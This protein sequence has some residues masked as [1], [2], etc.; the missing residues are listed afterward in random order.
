M[1]G[2][3]VTV[4]QKETG[5]S[6]TEYSENILNFAMQRSVELKDLTPIV[7]TTAA[8]CKAITKPVEFEVNDLLVQISTPS[9]I[10][11]P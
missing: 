10:I 7:T 5:L 4:T 11:I 6:Q 3:E 2:L 1:L 9:R 8:M